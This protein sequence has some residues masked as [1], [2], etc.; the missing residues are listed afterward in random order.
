MDLYM[1]IFCFIAGGI[2]VLL[3][4]GRSDVRE[5]IRCAAM[6]SISAAAWRINDDLVGVSIDIHGESAKDRQLLLIR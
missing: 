1:V 3:C 2:F 4:L 6:D 5:Y